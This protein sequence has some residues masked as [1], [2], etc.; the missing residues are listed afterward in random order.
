VGVRFITHVQ[1]G[2]GAHP[3]TRTVG[4]GL[5]PEVKR[6]GLDAEHTPLLTPRSQNGRTIPLSNLW[7]CSGLQREC[8]IFF[9]T[10][11]Q[12]FLPTTGYL[13]FKITD[14]QVKK[15]GFS[16]VKTMHTPMKGTSLNVLIS[17]VLYIE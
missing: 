2:H 3:A 6:P 10:Y 12:Q 11:T 13:K 1:T 17:N 7:A 5:F 14:L 9:F 16:T 4:T 15:K 8:F